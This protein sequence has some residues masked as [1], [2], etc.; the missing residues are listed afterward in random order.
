MKAAKEHKPQQSRVINRRYNHPSSCNIIQAY[1]LIHTEKQPCCFK[2]GGNNACFTDSNCKAIDRSQVFIGNGAAHSEE[3]MI[4]HMYSS[5]KIQKDIYLTQKQT[6]ANEYVQN[7]G[8]KTK[9]L[10]T[11]N[12]PCNGNY[13]QNFNCCNLLSIVLTESSKVFY[14]KA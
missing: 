1:T 13:G 10:Y 6:H 3:K 12:I 9:N 14:M 2:S 7:R 8:K 4:D 11:Y 5:D